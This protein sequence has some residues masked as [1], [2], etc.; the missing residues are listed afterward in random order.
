VRK[1]KTPE[2]APAM[3]DL[4]K[5]IQEGN[6]EA[7]MWATRAMIEHYPDQ[8]VALHK[9][10]ELR[11]KERD[12]RERGQQREARIREWKEPLD[13]E[14][15]KMMLM[16][17]ALG[18]LTIIDLKNRITKE[19]RETER[20]RAQQ[21]LHESAGAI[22]RMTIIAERYL[23]DHKKNIDKATRSL[24]RLHMTTKE[25]RNRATLAAKE[26][27]ERGDLLQRS[28]RQRSIAQWETK[29]RLRSKEVRTRHDM[30]PEDTT[31][32]EVPVTQMEDDDTEQWCVIGNG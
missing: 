3:A 25:K 31:Q 4:M 26:E 10:Q 2:P 27:R 32:W 5:E 19:N 18:S 29:V 12:E 23:K 16:C 7:S 20:R 11:A 15:D 17:E 8:Y 24:K 30:R 13:K 21:R 28:E 6:E 14:M 9:E 1:T 22:A